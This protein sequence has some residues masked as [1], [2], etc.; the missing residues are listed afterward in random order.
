MR[1][2]K[3]DNTASVPNIRALS[4]MSA[5]GLPH[6]A[7]IEAAKQMKIS[8]TEAEYLALDAAEED[9]RDLSIGNDPVDTKAV[10]NFKAIDHE[11]D[12]T[13][14]ESMKL[15]FAIQRAIIK[16]SEI[17]DVLKCHNIAH[18][19]DIRGATLRRAKKKM[20]FLERDARR[21]GGVGAERL[22]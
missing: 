3:L 1:K 4:R 9:S 2:D 17:V 5:T 6:E 7:T 22:D 15:D 8:M 12:L 16:I 18:A 11:L 13:E 21:R 10:S 19:Y 14:K 20:T